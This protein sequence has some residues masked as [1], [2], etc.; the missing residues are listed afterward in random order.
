MRNLAFDYILSG[1]RFFNATVKDYS[2][3]LALQFEKCF[4][5]GLPNIKN[6]Q[7]IIYVMQY[8]IKST[9]S[10]DIL[11]INRYVSNGAILTL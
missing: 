11:S 6:Y 3:V 10:N 4:S 9:D 5:V 2:F 8:T 7:L 1:V